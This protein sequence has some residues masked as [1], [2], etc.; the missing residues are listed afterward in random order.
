VLRRGYGDEVSG[1][2][3]RSPIANLLLTL[4]WFSKNMIA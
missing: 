2:G 3:S 1:E 4:L